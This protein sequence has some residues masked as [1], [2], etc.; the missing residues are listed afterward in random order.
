MPI[1]GDDV[2]LGMRDHL[3]DPRSDTC[4]SFDSNPQWDSPIS[5]LYFFDDSKKIETEVVTDL[6]DF[7]ICQGGLK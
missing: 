6:T 3:S 2:I 5:M 1:V 4:S 7:G